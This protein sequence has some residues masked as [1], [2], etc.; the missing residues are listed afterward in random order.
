[1]FRTIVAKKIGF[2]LQDYARN[3]DISSV[4]HF[5][6]ESQYWEESKIYDYR[7]KKLKNLVDHSYK[8][9][10]YYENLF[11]SIKLK[12]SD[13][14]TL[15]DIQKIPLLTKDIARKENM[16]LIAR[17][18]NLKLVRKGKT[19]GT[20]GSPLIVYKDTQN[21]SF[22]WAA[23]RRWYD[24]MGISYYDRSASIWGARSVLSASR[25]QR[26]IADVVRF[27][28]NSIS[29]NSFEMSPAELPNIYR[30]LKEFNP[31]I[32]RGYLSAILD[33]ARYIDK[34]NLTH[35]K[36]KAISTTTESLL[37]H[38][39]VYL[40]KVFAA[41]VYDQYGCGELSA[42][43]YECSKHNGLHVN[44]EHMVIEILDDEHKSIM[45]YKGRIVGTDL[46]NYVMPFIRYENG[47]MATMYTRKCDCGINQ[48]LMSSIEGRSADTIELKNG[49]KVHGVFI[50]DILYELYILTDTVQRFQAIQYQPGQL[51][52]TLET[53]KNLSTS[54]LK[55]LELALHRFFEDVEIHTS[56]RIP[57]EENG[58]FRY[59]KV[60]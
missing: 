57:N 14:H 49:S 45:N 43:S 47:D 20:T 53:D 48:P 54:L 46:D 31:V 5:L 2:P 38:Y 19:G 13:I 6:K 7:L 36:P 26:I 35:L 52:L 11:K 24:W 25:K 30:K 28:Q 9:V 12:P 55:E 16:N 50:T 29:I 58:K 17:G 41:P 56:S 33:I 10:P 1:M 18:S 32:I 23:D 4:Y 42:I 40:Q 21:R 44:Q 59:I 22:T 37:P 27:L 34:E 60:I 51:S 15:E 8:N 3:T 39:R